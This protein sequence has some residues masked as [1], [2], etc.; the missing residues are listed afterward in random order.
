MHRLDDPTDNAG[1]GWR[2]LGP[3]EVADIAY[4]A[5]RLSARG[6]KVDLAGRNADKADAAAK[7]LSKAVAARLRAYPT[8]GPA[9]PSSSHS[10]AAPPRS[11]AREGGVQK[12]RTPFVDTGEPAAER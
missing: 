6:M 12:V 4:F 7:A 1:R 8:F 11:E 10:T 3:D 2:Q 9:R 5:I